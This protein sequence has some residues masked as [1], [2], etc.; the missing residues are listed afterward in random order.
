V[1]NLISN[2]SSDW[3]GAATWALVETGTG[4]TQT[5]R[6][7]STN[8]TTSYVYSSAFT[9]TNTNVVDGV[10]L[11]IDRVTT[12]GTFSVALSE[13]NGTTATREVTINASDLG[14][15][16]GWV[17]FK[18]GSTLTLDGGTD[19]KVGIKGSSAGNVAVHRD[20]TAGNWT[21]LLRRTT[22]ATAAAADN[23]Y[24]VGEWTAAGTGTDITVTMNST[25]ATDYGTLDIGDRGVLTWGTTAATA[26]ILQLSGNLNIWEGG[27]YN[28]GT[29]ATPMPRDS[30]ATLQFDC[31]TDG[32]FGLIVNSGGTAVLQGQS[33]TSGKDIDRCLLN[34]DEA[35]ASTS[36]G[37]DTDTGWLDNDRI[38]I[39]TTTQTATQC[40]TGLLNGNAGAS[41]LTVDGFGG[42]GGGLAF[43]HSGTSPTQAE[44]ILLTRNVVVRS[45][46]T[47]AMAYVNGAAGGNINCDWVEFRYLGENATSKKGIELAT[48]TGVVTLDY[49]SICDCE[50][51]GLH[52]TGATLTGSITVNDLVM[53]NCASVN[54]TSAIN[55]AAT[56]GAPVFNDVIV[57]R[58]AST[59]TAVSFQDVG[60]TVNGVTVAGAS[61]SGITVAQSETTPLRSGFSNLT[62]HG[63]TSYGCNITSSSL[64]IQNVKF[65]RNGSYGLYFSPTNTI[66]DGGSIFGN[67]TANVYY[68]GG[69]GGF[70]NITAGGDTSFATTYNLYIAVYVMDLLLTACDF[71]TVS[72]IKTAATADLIVGFAH[73]S[74]EA[75]LNNCKLGAATEVSG[76]A[77][78]APRGRITSQRNDQTD[79][80]HVT[81]L[82]YGRRQADA[83]I[84][85]TAAPSERVTPITATAPNKV[86]TGSRYVAVDDA[87]TKTISVYVRKSQTGDGTQYNGNQPRL[88]VKRNDAL[89]ISSDTVLDT[90]T[91]AVGT[92]EQ[93][94]GTTAAATDDG[95]FEVVVDCDGTAGW[96]NVDDWSVS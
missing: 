66:I 19:Y 63:C 5:T 9:G 52:L 7:A 43:D 31:A 45:V 16:P 76:Q 93:L 82:T 65:W 6:S 26:Y 92:W 3:T 20:A 58:V 74:G 56:T 59:T 57:I 68:V 34:T 32:E 77:S 41:S 14:P 84:Y 30:T 69:H 87:G 47:T 96:I 54:G 95:A 53:Y 73:I 25:V 49:C 33:R 78:L 15:E 81:W 79:G 28:Q 46:S 75:R 72:G 71:S 12:T 80:N 86:E 11:Y 29:V 89:G 4:A 91:A 27:T 21:R 48:T 70:L 62:A 8:T 13:D 42:A 35:I 64:Y 94:T 55:V 39:A 90:M 61:G 67:T 88:I 44:V 24:I 60:L 51:G 23:L 38:A 1:A 83:T 22:A 37:V 50:D 2:A 36:L 85:N 18:F 17:F 10:L 40:E